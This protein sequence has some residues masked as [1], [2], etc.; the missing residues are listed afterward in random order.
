[1]SKL[2]GYRN[3]YVCIFWSEIFW[4]ATEQALSLKST[5]KQRAVDVR[6]VPTSAFRSSFEGTEEELISIL[7]HVSNTLYS[8][9]KLARSEPIFV[10]GIILSAHDITH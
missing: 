3:T 1:M 10:R 6:G 9:K 7:S 5:G 2:L 8:P 4:R